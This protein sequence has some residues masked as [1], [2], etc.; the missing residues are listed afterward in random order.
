MSQPETP[1]DDQGF[2]VPADETGDRLP[3]RTSWTKSPRFRIG[4]IVVA[5]L[6][7][8]ALFF[9]DNL[10]AHSFIVSANG[11]IHQGD[12]VGA[13]EDIEKANEWLPD[14][15]YLILGRAELR[16]RA[17][18]LEESLADYNWLLEKDDP[19]PEL[20][21]MRSIVH[22]RMKNFDLALADC[23]KFGE[24][25]PQRRDIAL[26]QRAYY[27][28]LAEKDLDKALKDIEEAISLLG[29][30][31]AS[32]LDTR[33]Y[34]LHLL[35]NHEQALVDLDQAI[36]LSVD[37]HRQ[38]NQDSVSANP[39]AG[40]GLNIKISRET[41]AVLYHHRG[42]IHRALGNEADAT[43]DLSRGD[44]MGYDPEKGVW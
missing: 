11:K 31:E 15:P 13:L 43:R 3:P 4:L 33:G 40:T 10:V 21:T 16:L 18:Q 37:R 24:L 27:R 9:G 42:Q 39:P 30:S 19:E 25:V 8:L 12:L 2:P 32:Y 35:G 20:Y 5:V 36:E 28:A 26:K 14:E 23:D 29:D 1:T 6:G 34:V 44:E 7:L 22:Q 17:N 38:L 41:L